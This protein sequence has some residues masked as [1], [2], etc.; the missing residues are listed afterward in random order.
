MK[1]EV[2]GQNKNLKN[3][4]DEMPKVTSEAT[5]NADER[6]ILQPQVAFFSLQKIRSWLLMKFVSSIKSITI[7][8]PQ[9]YT[10]DKA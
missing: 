4:T 8:C 10:N 5:S 9:L 2:K 1:F 6:P 3:S 7:N